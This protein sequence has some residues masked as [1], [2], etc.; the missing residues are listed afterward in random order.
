MKTHL[1]ILATIGLP[2]AVALSAGSAQA[3]F[4]IV[5][6][7][8]AA[9]RPDSGVVACAGGFCQTR[10]MPAQV[11]DLGAMTAANTTVLSDDLTAQKPGYGITNY[12]AKLDINF[13]ITDYLAVNDGT[14]GG[15]QLEV[16]YTGQRG[17]TPPENLHW[18]QIVTDNWNITGVNGN[19][20]SAPTGRGQ[21]ENVVD[22]P[23]VASPYYDD[24][25]K[26]QPPPNNFNTD[27]PHFEDFS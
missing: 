20:L 10:L 4:T 12:G 15:G 22:A 3:A 17:F 25:S 27:P 1:K 8:G 2:V 7:T 13:V 18:I 9:Y 14:S 23:G 11:V 6:A 21:P 26:A 24:A 5:Q 16:D 19:N